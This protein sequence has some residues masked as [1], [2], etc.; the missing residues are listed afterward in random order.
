MKRILP[1][2]LLLLTVVSASYAQN[3]NMPAP[4]PHQVLK[5]DFALSSI[6]IDYSRPGVKGRTIFGDLVP[7]GKVWRTG[8]NAVTTIE[9]GENV[10]VEG[11]NVPAGKYAIYTIPGENEWTIILNND[12]KNWGTEYKGGDDFLRFTVPSFQIG[13][14]VETFTIQVDGIRNDSATVYFLWDHTYV[15]FSVTADVDGTILS[16][17]DKGMQSDKKPY[18]SAASYYFQT[19]RDPKKALEWVNAATAENPKAYY[20]FYLKAELQARLGDKSGAIATA[21]Q[22]IDLAKEAKNDDY[23]RLNEKLIHSLQ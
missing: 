5:Q 11:H 4:S 15:P 10:K 19:N 18:F 14:A 20:M 22:S 3:I 12:V 23:V 7:Y 1:V 21:K 9:F 16:E 8:A 6:T 13:E 17:I 2:A